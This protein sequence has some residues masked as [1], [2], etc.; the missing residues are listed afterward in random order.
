VWNDPFPALEADTTANPSRRIAL[1]DFLTRAFH[2]G[3][4]AIAR[5]NRGTGKSGL[6]TIDN[7]VQEVLERTAMV[8]DDRFVETRFFMG[9]PA[10]GRRISGK[11]AVDMFFQELPGIVEQSLFSKSLDPKALARHL[12]TVE[13]ADALRK[14][15]YDRWD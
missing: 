9:L 7:P 11:Q 3:C 2:A 4:E 1:C 8:V 13:D 10:R 12:E 5:G 15:L 14:T 6:I